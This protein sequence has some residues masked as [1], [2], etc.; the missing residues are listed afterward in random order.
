MQEHRYLALLHKIKM[1]A[2]ILVAF[3]LWNLCLHFDK[4]FACISFLSILLLLLF[5]LLL[6]LLLLF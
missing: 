5:L 4:F 6:L 1:H 3:I 2:G